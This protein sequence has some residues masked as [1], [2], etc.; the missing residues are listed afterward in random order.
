MTGKHTVLI[1]NR[2][3]QYKFSV[4]RNITVLKG[5]SATGKTTLIDMLFEYRRNGE[6]SG[7]S[8]L[9]D[10]KCEVLTGVRWKENLSS[11]KDSIVFID[12]GDSFV[13]SEDFAIAVKNSDNYYVIATRSNLYNLPYSIKEVYGIR[14]VSGNKY[15][16]TKR[17][18]SEFYKLYENNPN[19]DGTPECVITEDSN[20]GFEFIENVFGERMPC[21]SACGKSNIWREIIKR[22]EN[23]V[24]VFADGSA[25]GCEIERLL[26]LRYVKNLL[27]YMPESF[28]YVLLKSGL[29]V[30]VENLLEN[31]YDHIE[32]SLFFSWERYFTKI[33]TEKTYGTYFEYSKEHIN[34]NYLHEKEKAKILKVLDI[35]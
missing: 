22:K 8:V 7:I 33:I 4:E 9:C 2:R 23:T 1:K 28:E 35:K 29:I 34:P 13:L 12:E 18:Y 17:I 6:D 11:V 25:F 5:D 16:G 27:V 19:N 14:N 24:A 10:K 3:V 32:S 21:V 30:G 15:E 31:P 26:S 20:S